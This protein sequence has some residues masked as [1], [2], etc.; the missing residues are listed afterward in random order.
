VGSAKKLHPRLDNLPPLGGWDGF[1][2]RIIFQ[3]TDLP[4]N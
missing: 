1:Q 4:I 3:S 2:T